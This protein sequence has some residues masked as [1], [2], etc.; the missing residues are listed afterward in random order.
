MSDTQDLVGIIRNHGEKDPRLSRSDLM[1]LNF[2]RKWAQIFNDNFLNGTGGRKACDAHAV[3]SKDRLEVCVSTQ[4]YYKDE[5]KFSCTHAGGA[6]R[7]YFVMPEFGPNPLPRT[8][9]SPFVHAVGWTGAALKYI[10]ARAELVFIE[11]KEAGA[12]YG[13]AAGMFAGAAVLVLFGYTFLLIA[14]VFGIA[15]LF[16]SDYAWIIVMGGL[17][18]LHIA[19]ALVLVLI[20]RRRLKTGPFVQTKEEFKKDQ[21]WLS[22]S[23]KNP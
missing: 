21:L 14:A 1:G 18:L 15:L 3:P 8:A 17:A 10:K 9:H 6:C 20:G 12:H 5:Q 19:G 7:N 22:H 23:A 13:A 2:S 11:V 4:N 16:D